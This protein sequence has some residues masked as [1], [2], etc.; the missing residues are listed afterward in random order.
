MSAG[1]PG[2]GLGGLFFIFSALAA[3]FPEL[4][5][6]ARGRS[7]T[8]AWRGILRQLAQALTMIVAV[9]LV[10]RLAGTGLRLDL[11]G[12]TTGILVAVLCAAKAAELRLRNRARRERRRRRS[13]LRAPAGN[14]IE[15]LQER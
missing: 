5:R 13:R 9:D 11:I 6:T 15:L 14:P 8:A 3:P 4:W 7:S 10:L 12:I 2:L 1:L